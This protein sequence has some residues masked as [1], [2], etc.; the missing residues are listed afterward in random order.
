MILLLYQNWLLFSNNNTTVVTTI[1][2]KR[3]GPKCPLNNYHLHYYSFS[4]L[5]Q[6][7]VILSCGTVP[8]RTF[9]LCLNIFL[10]TGTVAFWK[11]LL[12]LITEVT[13]NYNRID[14]Y[15]HFHEINRK[16]LVQHWLSNLKI[17]LANNSF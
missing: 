17:G 2:L 3:V 11:I 7:I 8:Y 6:I 1:A 9:G 15:L 10:C 4:K 14:K 12:C 13:Y 16:Q 5:Y